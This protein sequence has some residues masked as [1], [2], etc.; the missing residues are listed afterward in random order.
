MAESDFKGGA[1]GT[2]D[3][4]QVSTKTAKKVV[5]QQSPKHELKEDSPDSENNSKEFAEL[6]PSRKS[7]RT[8]GKTFKYILCP[9]Y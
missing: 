2:S 5:E 6:T 3:R 4:K 1:G 7:A 9:S 8:A